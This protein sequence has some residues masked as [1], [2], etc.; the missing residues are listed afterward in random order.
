MVSSSSVSPSPARRSI[1][2]PLLLYDA[3][4]HHLPLTQLVEVLFEVDFEDE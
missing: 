3:R 1:L 4:T 2:P